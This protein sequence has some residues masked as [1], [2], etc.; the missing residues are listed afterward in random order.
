MARGR[1]ADPPEVLEV[2]DGQPVPGQVQERIEEH[3][4]VAGREH[5]AVA[6][7]PL[8]VRR[9]VLHHPGVE[10]VAERS[11]PHRRPRVPGVRLLD[12]VHRERPDRVDAELVERGLLAYLGRHLAPSFAFSGVSLVPRS[13]CLASRPAPITPASAPL[14]ATETVTRSHRTGNARTPASTTASSR[15]RSAASER[16]PPIT[17]CSGSNAFTKPAIPTPSASARRAN[18]APARP[19]PTP[20]PS[21]SITRSRTSRSSASA[22]AAQL[23]SLSTKAGTPK[24]CPS[25]SRR[26]TPSSGMFTLDI[27]RPVA[28]SIWDGTPAPIA[29]GR[30]MSAITS[31]TV[32]S[33]PSSSASELSSSVGRSTAPLTLEPDTAPASTFVPPTSTPRTTGSETTRHSLHAMTPGARARGSAVSAVDPP[34]DPLR[35]A[36]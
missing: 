32:A 20:V 29:A 10:E 34:H 25:S 27:T 19:S 14:W 30:P 2:V 11:E 35:Q 18:K 26:A 4:R 24:R 5:E 8:R 7:E 36:A 3:R 15:N 31:C 13:S 23:P 12:G 1:A 16:P 22:R 21:V 17:S 9:V 28:N 33:S 6:V